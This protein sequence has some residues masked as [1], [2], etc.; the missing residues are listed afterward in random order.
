MILLI[1]GLGSTADM[2]QLQ[3]PV[4][5][6]NGFRPVAMDIPGF[7]QSHFLKK[8]WSIR[9]AA[10]TLVE[11]LDMKQVDRADIVGISMGGTVALTLALD[12]PERVRRLVLVNTFARLRPDT[13]G[14]WFYFLKR[15]VMISTM[16]MEA[17]ARFVSQRIFPGPDQAELREELFKQVMQADPAAYRGTMKALGL[18]DVHQRLREIQA[19]TL[20]VTGANDTT[21]RPA[22]Q[23]EL[24]L[25]IP[26]A[27]QVMIPRAGH[28]VVIDQAEVFN[29]ELVDF[30]KS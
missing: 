25:K 27:R 18:F 3:M 12:Y 17:Q 24:A 20:V 16:G 10:G 5:E 19:R 11:Y 13:A 30:L 9:R 8:G 4:L 22:N 1:H 7:G 26:N 2:W 29:Q 21:V 23:A 15:A 28:A 6:Q 14:G